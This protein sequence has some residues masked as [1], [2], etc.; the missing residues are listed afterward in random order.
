MGGGG[1]GDAPGESDNE[2][3]S[4]SSSA[5]NN[6]RHSRP[7]AGYWE[8]VANVARL[9]DIRLA[10]VTKHAAL[11][12]L[13]EIKTLER[14]PSADQ[15]ELCRLRR[16]RD[17]AVHPQSE[18]PIAMPLRLSMIVPV[19]LALDGLMLSARTPIQVALAQWTNQS[20]NALHYYA[21]RNTSNS[22]SMSQ[23]AAAYVL[24]TSG[25]VGVALKLRSLGKA[26]V[27][28][29]RRGGRVLGL[30]APFFAVA[31]ADVI[32]LSIM[33]KNEFLQG[34]KV[35][36][37]DRGEL[38]GSSQRAG[39][40]ATGACIVARVAA[41]FPIL[42]GTPVI[43]AVLDRK[44]V[45]AKIP[46]ARTPFMLGTIGVM[47]QCAVPLTFGVFERE[48][49]VDVSRLEPCLESKCPSGRVVFNKGL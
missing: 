38:V 41:A 18:Q 13:E 4:S 29:N 42:A 49:Q 1:G 24:A 46:R 39:V 34:I 45:F 14:D 10:L 3:T 35:Y 6:A 9:L 7:A 17:A 30:L 48:M 15:E 36:D 23:R 25:S 28:S 5:E 26:A 22:E 33:R 37:A 31:S 16:I 32:N 21:N 19:N 47:I 11:D 43:M 27:A 2:R 8:R 20:Y 44:Q 40:L 12:A